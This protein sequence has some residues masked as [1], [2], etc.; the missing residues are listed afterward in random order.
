[1]VIDMVGSNVGLIVII[2]LSPPPTMVEYYDTTST[3][4]MK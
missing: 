1:M 2:G 3:S 4:E